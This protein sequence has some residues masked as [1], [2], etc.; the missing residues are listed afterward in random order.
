MTSLYAMA[1]GGAGG[2]G[3]LGGLGAFIPFILI[4]VV[5]YFLLIRPQRQKEQEHKKML[6]ALKKEDKVVTSG[7]IY[8]KIVDIKDR[9]ITLEVAK[10]VKIE[11]LKGAIGSKVKQ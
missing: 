11:V 7:G 6:D 5:F 4:F 2:G 1:G 8:G 3:G 9:K 10:G